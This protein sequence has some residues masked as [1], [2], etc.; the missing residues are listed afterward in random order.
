[1]RKILS[2]FGI[3]VLVLS[4]CRNVDFREN[5]ENNTT[6]LGKNEASLFVDILGAKFEGKNLIAAN[7]DEQGVSNDRGGG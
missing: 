1:M 2:Y 7:P 6:D 3:L 4:S 5:A